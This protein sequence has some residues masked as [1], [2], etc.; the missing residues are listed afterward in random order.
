MSSRIQK[1]VYGSRVFGSRGYGLLLFLWIALVTGCAT[2]P[3]DYSALKAANPQSI[4]VIPPM[5]NSVEVNAPYIFI[6]SI[7]SALAEKGYYVFPVAL[8][9]QF[10]KDNGLPTPA[11]MNAAPLDKL[12]SIFGADAVLYVTIDDWG[13]QYQVLSSVAVVSSHWRLVD[14]R[15][16][17]ELWS[18]RAYAQESSGDGGGGL[19]GMLVSAVVTQIA[20]SISDPTP[21]LSKIATYSAVNNQRVGLLPGPYLRAKGQA[22]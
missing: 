8:V 17:L 1:R 14:A 11:E 4:L 18:G 2:Q 10:M 20:G 16:G 5:N 6:S 13:Q 15:T 9:D 7:S 12:Q 3:F 21:R 22:Q 19:G